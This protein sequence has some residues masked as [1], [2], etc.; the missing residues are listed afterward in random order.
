MFIHL[1][2]ET[3]ENQSQSATDCPYF[4]SMHSDIIAQCVSS[5]VF[6]YSLSEV[7]ITLAPGAP[8]APEVLPQTHDF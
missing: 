6:R 5:S 1:M 7:F 2:Q 4:C 3:L 8:G